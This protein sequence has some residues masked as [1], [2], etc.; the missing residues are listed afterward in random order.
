MKGRTMMLSEPLW[1][2]LVHAADRL[3]ASAGRPVYGFKKE[4]LRSQSSVD[5]RFGARCIQS[6]VKIMGFQRR[7]GGHLG[8][9]YPVGSFWRWETEV[10]RG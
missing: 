5:R 6:I 10:Q 1:K 8:W 2:Y 7:E 3:K 9:W 4:A